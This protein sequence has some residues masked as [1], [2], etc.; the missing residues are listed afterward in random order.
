MLVVDSKLTT[1]GS[2]GF[3]IVNP[4]NEKI[5]DVLKVICIHAR[6]VNFDYAKV[7]LKRRIHEKYCHWRVISRLIFIRLHFDAH[8]LTFLWSEL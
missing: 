4:C 3:F 6:L 1:D 8:Q 7:A 5:R 2:V